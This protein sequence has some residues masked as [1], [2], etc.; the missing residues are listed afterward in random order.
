MRCCSKKNT[1]FK[2]FLDSETTADPYAQYPIESFE[3]DRKANEIK[4]VL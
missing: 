4:Y 2:K 3:I 1:N